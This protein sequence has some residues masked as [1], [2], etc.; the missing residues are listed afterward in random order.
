V[1]PPRLQV[2][3]E[4]NPASDAVEAVS[5]TIG[6]LPYVVT[7]ARATRVRPTE[8]PGADEGHADHGVGHAD[9]VGF[10]PCCGDGCGF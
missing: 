2:L 7:A 10:K 3:L 1:L 5:V 4:A 6:V 8:M 9:C